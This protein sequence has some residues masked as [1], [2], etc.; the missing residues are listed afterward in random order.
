[1][2][3]L[4]R[5]QR[6]E[7]V[8][9]EES[10]G[11]AGWADFWTKKEKWNQKFDNLTSSPMF[12]MSKY[13]PCNIPNV[14]YSF[15]DRDYKL[16]AYLTDSRLKR[17][18]HPPLFETH[19]SANPAGFLRLYLDRI[20]RICKL[21][22]DGRQLILR[23]S[24]RGD[25]FAV[26]VGWVFVTQ[27]VCVVWLNAIKTSPLCFNPS[28]GDYTHRRELEGAGR[29]FLKGGWKYDYKSLPGRT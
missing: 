23:L 2:D 29:Y 20:A 1:M 22:M 7:W 9:A 27:R 14:P 10:E 11:S 4:A 17:A 24:I 8:A 16:S 12:A 3:R 5:C 6:S 13:P 18:S 15:K 25:A 28:E 26:W 21:Q 19:R